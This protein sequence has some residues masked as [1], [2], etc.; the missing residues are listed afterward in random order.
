MT[1]AISNLTYAWP[2][3]SRFRLRIPSFSLADGETVFLHGASGGGK[4][5]FLGLLGG[6][7]VPQSGSLA[8]LGHDLA[9]MSG[10]ARDRFRVDHIG[11]IFQQF[12]LLPYLSVLE[13][14][15]L[16]CRF[17]DVRAERAMM[18]SS[19]H[20]LEDMARNLMRRLELEDELAR[21]PAGSLSVGQQQRVSVAR[22]L[23]GRPALILADEP[24]SA[25]DANRKVAFLDL[26]L[27][28]GK[29][30]GA[31]I[32]FVSHDETLAH[33]FGRRLSISSFADGV[34]P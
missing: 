15:L 8:I 28:Q 34:A 18:D 20:S 5:T 33:H 13:N 4:S 11:V 31:T 25:L 22:A 29:G 17:S 23:I 27:G 19:G 24:T 30:I 7:L 32:V 9:G 3:N 16:P 10:A 14:I 12:N 21:R 1:I 6:V 2:G 26:L